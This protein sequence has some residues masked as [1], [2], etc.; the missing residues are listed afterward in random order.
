MGIEGLPHLAA[1]AVMR[2]V[3]SISEK[4]AE[5]TAVRKNFQTESFIKFYGDPK[6]SREQKEAKLNEFIKS[7]PA[8]QK[9]KDSDSKFKKLTPE[10]IICNYFLKKNYFVHIYN[11]NVTGFVLVAPVKKVLQNI[12]EAP[13]KNLFEEKHL[14]RKPPCYEFD[15]KDYDPSGGAMTGFVFTNKSGI[16]RDRKLAKNLFPQNIGLPVDHSHPDLITQ[17]LY[18]HEVAHYVLENV[19]RIDDRKGLDPKNIIIEK[20]DLRF[21]NI[22]QM[23]EF[24]GYTA[25][26]L[27]APEMMAP[28]F[29]NHYTPD[30]FKGDHKEQAHMKLLAELLSERLGAKGISIQTQLNELKNLPY[31]KSN[32]N[33]RKELVKDIFSK[34]DLNDIKA[35]QEKFLT[36]SRQIISE[37]QK[38]PVN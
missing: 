16:D 30:T 15:V 31:S 32:L 5:L 24:V 17:N 6:I 20:S 34:L 28:S 4:D 13:L 35:I 25:S 22:L 21:Q 19:L 12:P 23:H 7:Q 36:V 14:M 11:I 1:K 29:L 37:I 18:N 3:N 27:T 2:S 26:Y 33:R 9:Y 38:Y 10:T 8:I